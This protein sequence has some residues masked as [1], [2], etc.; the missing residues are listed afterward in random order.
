MKIFAPND[1]DR[2]SVSENLGKAAALPTLPLMTPCW[3]FEIWIYFLHDDTFKQGISLAKTSKWNWFNLGLKQCFQIH[4]KN[5]KNCTFK[6]CNFTAFKCNM[7][8]PP[9]RWIAHSWPHIYV[10]LIRKQAL[11]GYQNFAT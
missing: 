9:H 3:R 2:V 6:E 1:W 4:D 8:H 11:R 7:T 5:S 10:S